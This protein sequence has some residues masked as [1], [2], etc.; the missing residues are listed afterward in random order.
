MTQV[1]PIHLLGGSWLFWIQTMTPISK[2]PSNA[3]TQRLDLKSSSWSSGFWTPLN[4]GL[5]LDCM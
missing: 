2:L 5:L 4:G 3:W 1:G